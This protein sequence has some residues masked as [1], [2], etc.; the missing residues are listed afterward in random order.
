M[1]PAALAAMTAAAMVAFAANSLLCRLALR[2]TTIDPVAF[3]FIRIGSGAVALLLLATLQRPRRRGNW[4]SAFA[5]FAYAAGFSLAYVR[6][7]AAVG[8]LLLFASVQATMISWGLR[9]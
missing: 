2:H 4:G 6:L 5:L 8:A 9:K 1:R 3:T 7:G